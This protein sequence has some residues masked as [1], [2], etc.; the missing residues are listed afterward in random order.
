MEPQRPQ[1]AR[2]ILRK[3]NKVWRYHT[4]WFQ[5]IYYKN[6]VTKILCMV[7]KRVWY[8]HKMRHTDQCDRN[9]KPKVNS[10]KYGQLILDKRVKNTHWGNGSPLN[11]AGKTGSSHPEEWKWNFISHHSQKLTGN[12]LKT[13]V[14]LKV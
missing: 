4:F 6:K 13:T 14:D 9:K 7:F 1:I 2:E 12:E 5:A 11:S 10:C 3:K 8:W